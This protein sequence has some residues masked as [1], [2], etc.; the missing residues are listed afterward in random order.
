[1]K[2]AGPGVQGTKIF[3]GYDDDDHMLACRRVFPNPRYCMDLLDQLAVL[4]VTYVTGASPDHGLT[5]PYHRPTDLDLSHLVLGLAQC[6]DPRVRD[7]LVSLLLH[8]PESASAAKEVISSPETTRGTR[9]SLTARLLAAAALQRSYKAAFLSH[10]PR[11][12]LIDVTDL[13]SAEGLPSADEHNGRTLLKNVQHLV[14][15]K[16]PTIDYLDG[17]EDVARHTL[18]EMSWAQVSEQSLALE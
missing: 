18:Q 13:T 3:V 2:S 15:S 5:S 12:R 17:W 14:A 7:A 10:E 6:P 1:M 11:Y 9:A 8:H 16:T 4:D